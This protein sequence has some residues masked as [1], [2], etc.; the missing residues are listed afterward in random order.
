MKSTDYIIL[1]PKR[2]AYVAENVWTEVLENGMA[3]AD[4][5]SALAYVRAGIESDKASKSCGEVHPEVDVH[6]EGGHPTNPRPR[7]I[8]CRVT[9]LLRASIDELLRQGFHAEASS[10][11]ILLVVKRAQVAE[12]RKSWPRTCHGIPLVLSQDG[13]AL[14]WE[15]HR[16]NS[17]PPVHW[18]KSR[19]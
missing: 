15:V 18:G 14:A 16:T 1:S 5:E 13:L 4:K 8:G 19:R 2:E 17:K 9:S 10:S 12:A 3:F 6:H 7:F 11:G